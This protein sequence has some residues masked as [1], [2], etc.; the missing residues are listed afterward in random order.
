MGDLAHAF[1][2][3]VKRDDLPPAILEALGRFVTGAPRRVMEP[4]RAH[5]YEEL[6]ER[7]ILGGRM[8]QALLGART[9]VGE[10]VT[11]VLWSLIMVAPMEQLRLY[12]SSLP[13][14]VLAQI[15]ESAHAR[16]GSLLKTC[17]SQSFSLLTLPDVHVEP[18]PN[19]SLRQS[20]LKSTQ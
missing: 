1:E 5:V 20:L 13:P 2:A 4:T 10:P 7:K 15:L 17:E 19:T 18:A 9:A 12:D 6:E 14:F 8:T 3:F 16:L 11:A